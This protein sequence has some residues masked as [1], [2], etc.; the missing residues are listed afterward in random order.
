MNGVD[1]GVEGR[2]SESFEVK[3][4]ILSVRRG[5]LGTPS[6]GDECD[7]RL[8]DKSRVINFV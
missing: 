2:K 7:I 6:R 5:W 4:L 1:D 3:E 8:A